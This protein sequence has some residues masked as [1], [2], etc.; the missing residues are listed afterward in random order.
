MDFE[1]LFP[2]VDRIPGAEF[3]MAFLFY[4]GIIAFVIIV[5]RL[6]RLHVFIHIPYRALRYA[7]TKVFMAIVYLALLFWLAQE[8]PSQYPNILA[9]LAF[10]SAA[11]IV[12]LQDVIKGFVGWLTQSQYLGLGQRVTIGTSNE[13]MTGDVVDVGILYTS[14]LIARTPELKN[15]S[16]VGKIV[17]IPN[18]A[19]LAYPLINYNSTS[20]FLR[21][22]I[23][24]NVRDA[25]Q[26]DTAKSIFER[27]VEEFTN[28]YFE[29]ARKQIERR[30]RRF[31]YPPEFNASAVFS[32]IQ[33]DGVHFTLCFL[34]PIRRKRV[35]IT[36]ITQAIVERCKEAKIEIVFGEGE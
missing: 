20:D 8:I 33:T 29:A 11:L 34:V 35:I 27:V 13:P 9:S 5:E 31:F 17:R 6:I 15:V 12:C 21:V 16:Q 22:E 14:L 3:G 10:V 36:E 24:I 28:L 4:F 23:P 25:R 1:K 2:F 30:A 18:S 19:L 7:L 32:E 26:Y